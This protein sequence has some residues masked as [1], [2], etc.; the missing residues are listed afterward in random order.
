[1][2]IIYII[3]GPNLNF[4]G[5]RQ[6]EIYGLVT[7]IKIVED[8]STKYQGK[9]NFKYLQTNCEGNIVD[10]LQSAYMDTNCIGI[11][12]NPAAYSHTS[13]A[14][15]DCYSYSNKKIVEVHLSDYTQREEYRKHSLTGQKADKLIYG[16]GSLG[17]FKAAEYLTLEENDDKS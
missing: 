4:L 5:T 8:L 2:S 1:M 9:I 11:I 15:L 17:Y 7:D 10:F 3:N 13:I 16:L 14:I 12:I 6:P